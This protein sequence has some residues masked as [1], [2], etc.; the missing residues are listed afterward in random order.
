[1]KG[2]VAIEPRKSVFFIMVKKWFPKRGYL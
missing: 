2:L 1:L